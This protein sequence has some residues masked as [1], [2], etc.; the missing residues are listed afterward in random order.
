MAHC[1]NLITTHKEDESYF[2]I[3][4]DF[5]K[6]KWRS[7]M[8]TI[9]QQQAIIIAFEG[10]DA[11]TKPDIFIAFGNQTNEVKVYDMT[12]IIGKVLDNALGHMDLNIVD[13]DQRKAIYKEREKKDYTEKDLKKP[14]KVQGGISS[15]KIT[16]TEGQNS[17]SLA[18][19]LFQQHK[20]HVHINLFTPQDKVERKNQKKE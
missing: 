1:A 13:P 10:Y 20:V 5:D 9:I 18:E 12:Y 2:D 8:E 7:T 19:A 14:I 4:K 11:D 17:I 6:S 3:Y 15:L 16:P